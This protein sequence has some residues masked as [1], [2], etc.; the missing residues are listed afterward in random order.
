MK[1]FW[2]SSI[3]ATV[4]ALAVAT[5]LNE[6]V[7]VTNE[8]I[9]TAIVGGVAVGGIAMCIDVTVLLICGA[10]QWLWKVTRRRLFPPISHQPID[11]V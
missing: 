3:T 8:I 2:I 5:S 6:D 7:T 11:G 10:I 4:V 9:M 1:T